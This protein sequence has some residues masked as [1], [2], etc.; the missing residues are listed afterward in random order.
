MMRLFLFLLPVS[1]LAAAAELRFCLRADPKTFNPLLVTEEAGEAVRYLTGG[2]LL[3]INRVTQQYE[4]EL[5]RSWRISERGR[6]IEFE[7]RPGLRFSD[8]T[9]LTA[10]HVAFTLRTLVDPQTQSPTGDPLRIKGQ[11]PRVETPSPL[12][13]RVTFAA[14]VAGLER[15]FDQV[16]IASPRSLEAAGDPARMPV[17]GP[18]RVAEYN[19]ALTCCLR[20]THIT[21]STTRPGAACRISATFVCTFNRIA[22]SNCAASRAARSI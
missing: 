21:G 14:P 13:C 1:M 9:P 19:R 6:R 11:P 8:G 16:A 7:L 12:R 22:I 2:V 15:L 17:A 10:E 20:P 4:P 18:Y 5:A 3:R